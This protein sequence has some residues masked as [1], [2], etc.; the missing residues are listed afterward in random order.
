VT[1]RAESLPA[2]VYTTAD[3]LA[4]NFVQSLAR[5]SRGFLWLC[6]RAGLSRF[7]GRAFKN[8]T[9]ADGLPHAT[10]NHLLE[11]RAGR[12]WVATNGGGVARFDP[13]RRGGGFTALRVGDTLQTNR[14]NRLYEDRRGVIWA[15]T[16]AGV[17]RLDEA[18]GES[19]FRFVEFEPGARPSDR[20]GAN[21]VVED[22]AGDLWVGA[23]LALVRVRADGRVETFSR[24]QVG[25]SSGF[26]LQL[27]TDA[28]GR[29]WVASFDRLC[30]LAPPP[31]AGASAA[32]RCLKVLDGSAGE[33]VNGLR[34]VGEGRTLVSSLRGLWEFDGEQVTRL[35]QAEPDE[36]YPQGDC[37][38][39]VEKNLWVATAGGGVMKLTRNGFT[40]F[41]E[42]ERGG[43]GFM[44]LGEDARGRILAAGGDGVLHR[45]E[46]GRFRRARLRVP[47]DATFNWLTS[48]V[49]P[50]R[51]GQVWSLTTTSGLFRFG[52]VEDL[53]SLSRARPAAGYGTATG[54]PSDAFFRAFED[55]RGDM[56]FS[57]ISAER[58]RLLRWERRTGDFRLYTVE[59]GLP[60]SNSA[61][62]FAE[63]SAGNLWL[64]F[65]EGGVARLRAGRFELYGAAEGFPQQMVTAIYPD[66]RG[67]LWV[68]SNAAGL[69]RVDDPGA[70][71]PAVTARYTAAG[72]LSG[73]DVRS[74]VEDDF[75]RLYVGTTRGLDRLDPSTGDVTHLGLDDGLPN[76]FI[77][78]SFRDSRGD[79][80][81]GAF[82]G[83]VRLAPRPEAASAPEVF[84][85]ALRAGARAHPVAELGEREVAD[86]EFSPEEGNVQVE[87]G[88]VSFRLGAGLRFRYRVEGGGGG[89]SA[90]TD[91]RSVNLSLAPGGYRLVVQAVSPSGAPLGGREASVSFTVLRPVWQRWWFVAGAAALCA[92]AGL[93]L[94][95]YRVRHL[96]AVERVRTR[97]ASDLHD[98]IGAS[99]SQI[100]VVSEVLRRQVGDGDERVGRNLNLMARVSREAVDAMSDIVWAINPSRDTLTDLVR[101][102]RRFASETLPNRDIE[103]VFGAP[104]DAETGRVRLGA[105]FRRE[106]FLIFKECVNNVLKHSG[107]TRAVVELRV[108]HGRLHVSV[109]DNGRGFAAAGSNGDADGLGGHGL[110]SMRRRAESLGGALEVVSADGAGTALTLSVPFKRRAHLN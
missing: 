75:G 79:L 102:M 10:V 104:P 90:P 30:R 16:D 107:S 12:Y 101:R 27:T 57:T 60:A 87:F 41:P 103:L 77:L 43:F 85:T 96:L 42:T 45:L 17:F 25:L 84:I 36:G 80:W 55:S 78:C 76:D 59:D 37:V 35:Y 91:Q 83:V 44:L 39:D 9:T 61:F 1:A 70:E 62:S 82:K 63:D 64:G 68:A 28:S 6:T 89:W 2:R 22:G 11:T 15:A 53:E 38:E 50:D 3:G 54:L 34:P 31:Q 108:R 74:V 13:A 65:Y 14:V 47:P 48:A 98:D 71:R 51:E 99:L 73:D 67:R 66:R 94:Y 46:G 49:Y 18:G 109:R 19:A 95:R 23:N 72:G 86:L 32:G 21:S 29:V 106:V 26:G 8:Y 5:D 88:A 92:L 110:A 100:A 7:D 33:Y 4:S 20:Y 81:F 69:A 56:W 58:D 52:E 105:D 97:I 40:R 24:G 93:A